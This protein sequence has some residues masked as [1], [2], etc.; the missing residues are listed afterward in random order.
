MHVQRND[1][2]KFN[3]RDIFPKS[4]SESFCPQEVEVSLSEVA[5]YAGG[6]RYRMDSKMEML[7]RSILN[8]AISLSLP[9][10]G[11]TV[12]KI[13]N[14]VPNKGFL[15]ENNILI[16]SPPY[17]P[18]DTASVVSVIC[19]IGPGLEEK[20]RSLNTKGM[21]IETLYLDASGVALLEAVVQQAHGRISELAR[22]TGLYCGCQWAPGY[23]KTSLED[24]KKLF[25]LVDASA[26]GVQL[27][28]SGAMY[29]FKSLSFW[30]PLTRHPVA[31]VNRN[32]CRHCSFKGCNYRI[33]H[34]VIKEVYPK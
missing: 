19:T 7:A 28:Q 10:F 8:Q 2:N 23:E 15:I 30:I 27:M 1:A 20:I 11:Y 6:S 32:K 4:G 9:A 14:T 17:I 25:D 16:P 12:H 24:Q 13:I 5:R 29:P 18:S 22:N 26:L 31:P 3:T 21:S 33:T 34:S